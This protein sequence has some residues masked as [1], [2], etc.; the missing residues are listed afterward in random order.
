MLISGNG[1]RNQ[2][3]DLSGPAAVNKL[4]IQFCMYHIKRGERQPQCFLLNTIEA[5]L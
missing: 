3:R 5:M 4:Y 1:V 2:V